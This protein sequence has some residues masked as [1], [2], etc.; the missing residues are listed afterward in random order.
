[1]ASSNKRFLG[2]FLGLTLA[3]TLVGVGL[4]W[5]VHNAGMLEVDIQSKGSG[6]CDISGIRIPAALGHIAIAMIPGH[7]FGLEGHD[8]E[9]WAPMLREACSE[10]ARC[11]DFTMVEVHSDDEHVRIRKKGNQLIVDVD[12]DDERVQ[13]TVPLGMA[14]AF[15][16]KLERIGRH[17]I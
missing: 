9:I 8:M 11:P 2:I 15:A 12:T 7:V 10:L 13:V 3:L 1:M 14:K 16:K 17:T 4:A 5:S 6:G